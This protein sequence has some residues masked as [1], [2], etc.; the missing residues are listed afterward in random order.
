MRFVMSLGIPAL[1]VLLASSGRLATAADMQV[2]I[3]CDFPGGNGIVEKNAGDQVQVAPDLRGGM[4]WFY[5]HFE[6]VASKPGLVKFSF[7]G[8][9]RL[10][11]Q[12]PAYSVDDGKT[13]KWLGLERCELPVATTPVAERLETFTYEFPP[14][15]LKARF[16]VAIPY[17]PE[18][19][20]AFIAAN[21]GNTHLK[22]SYLTKTRSGTPVELLQIGEA[23]PKRNAV[24]VSA[25]HHACESLAS[26]VLE[27]F[28]SEA[29]SESE[30]GADFRKRY[31]LLAVPMVDRDGVAAGDQGKNRDP[32]DHNRDYGP[33]SIYPEIVAIQQLGEAHDVKYAL[34]FHCPALRGD[35][36][37]AFH[38][39]GLG[40]PRVKENLD[41]FIG[42]IKE[43]R[44]EVLMTPLNYLVDAN[45]PN[46][47]NPKICSHHFALRN[48]AV[49]AA[50]LEVPYTQTSIPL[51]PDL[52]R[53]YGRGLLRAWVRTRF[54][55]S[56]AEQ[57]RGPAGYAELATLRKNFLKLYRSQPDEVAATATAYANNPDSPSALRSEALLLLALLRLHQRRA[58][59]AKTL[60]DDALKS[61]LT[62][63]Q[64]SVA[65][66]QRLQIAAGESETTGPQLEALLGTF[67]ALPYRGHEHQTKALEIVVKFFEAKQQYARAIHFARRQQSVAAL[68]ETGKVINHVAALHDLAGQ[69]EQAIAAR[70]EAV[71]LLRERLGPTPKRNIFAAMMTLDLFDAVCGIPSSTLADKQ[72]AAQLVLDHEVV[73]ESY[74]A[75]VR[76][77]LSELEKQ[78]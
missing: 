39:L 25:R 37:E 17:L 3:R 40:T 52:A 6:A 61:S 57:M 55:T 1:F 26:F 9:P 49:F 18:N 48:G 12:G 74:K 11:A 64:R 42:W 67:D 2:S 69:T 38:F 54:A 33:M 23:G 58:E 35:I 21:Q 46:G 72:S 78:P 70:E 14:D 77:Q 34:D 62:N 50:T 36:H 24:F 31:Y 28:L 10:S 73:A 59:D 75:L 65:W 22:A 15:R 60:L 45:K 51:T 27:G 8:S 63:D 44:P 56:D 5:W 4:P 29:M 19:L 32:H 47:V 53:E 71:K 41:E 16:A 76:K 20:H 66:I 43:E 30:A 13:W 68:H 7:R